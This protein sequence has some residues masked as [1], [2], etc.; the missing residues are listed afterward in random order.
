[1][2]GNRSNSIIILFPYVLCKYQIFI[3]KYK[4]L[5][6]VELYLLISE[7]YISE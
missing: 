4:S 6:Q 1:M 2:L 3:T 7:F 5:G